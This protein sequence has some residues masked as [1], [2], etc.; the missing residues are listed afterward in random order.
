MNYMRYEAL[1]L[2]TENATGAVSQTGLLCI[3]FA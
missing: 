2:L 3:L 1:N